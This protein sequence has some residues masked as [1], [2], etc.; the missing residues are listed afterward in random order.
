M[1]QK[2]P[3]TELYTYRTLLCTG[4]CS[5]IGAA[6]MCPEIIQYQDMV[7]AATRYFLTLDSVPTQCS[8]AWS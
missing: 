5:A 8:S 3:Q 6:A 4:T 7:C 1:K 2:E